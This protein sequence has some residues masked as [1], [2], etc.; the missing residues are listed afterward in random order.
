MDATD[1]TTEM[2]PY[3]VAMPLDEPAGES[4][5]IALEE[6]LYGVIDTHG[7]QASVVVSPSTD[8]IT[9]DPMIDATIWIEAGEDLN[10][11]T[12]LLIPA[13]ADWAESFGGDGQ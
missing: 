13:V 10:E 3:R 12:G 5:A 11:A 8:S 7:Y 1:S 4:D 2:R 9:D 6:Q